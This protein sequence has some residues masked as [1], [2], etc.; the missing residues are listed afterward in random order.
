[1]TWE[2]RVKKKQLKNLNKLPVNVKDDFM[3]LQRAL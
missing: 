1:M 2:V 3:F